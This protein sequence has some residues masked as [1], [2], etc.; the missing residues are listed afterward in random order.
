LWH[1]KEP[2][3]SMNCDVLAKFLV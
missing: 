2:S 3:T 1:V